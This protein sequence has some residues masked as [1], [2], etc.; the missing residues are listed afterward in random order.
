ME[1]LN[2]NS[3]NNNNLSIIDLGNCET[4]LKEKYNLNENDNLIILKKEKKTN[5][6]FEKEVQLEIYE[7]YNRT[8]LNISLCDETNINIYVKAKLSEEIKYSYEKLKSLGYDMFDINEPFYRDI[9]IDYTSYKDS[10]I[11]LSDRINYIYNNDDT[12]CQSNCK[13]YEYSEEYL[14][15]SSTIDEEINNMNEKF[16]STKKYESFSNDMK[17]SA[18]KVL[19]CYNLVFTKCLMA[20]NIGGILVFT[21]FLIYLGCFIIFIIK[22]INPLK[23]KFQLKVE[24]KYNNNI[25]NNINNND[26]ML[27]SKIDI[28]TNT[29]NKKSSNAVNPPRRKSTIQ[30]LNINNILDENDND[31][32]K[33]NANKND[34]KLADALKNNKLIIR[35][36]NKIQTAIN[37]TSKI[38]LEKMKQT[39]IKD[40]SNNK[41]DIFY[42]KI[43]NNSNQ[44]KNNE[45]KNEIEVKEEELD[46]LELNELDYKEAIKLDKRSFIQIYW[47][48]LKREQP[49]IFT[50]FIFDDYINLIYIK[51]VRFI[52]ILL[53]DMTMNVFSFLQMKQ[54]INYI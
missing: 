15:C 2:N 52:F 38:D 9:C 51:L 22:R 27:S 25:I 18:Y 8:K 7:P 43:S 40:I 48:I 30:L 33:T 5:K 26:I 23:N 46:N 20:K 29:K 41:F 53:T 36:N 45:N 17:Y 11:I 1:T 6:A 47:G 10:D 49:I 21:F 14:N 44:N 24:E 50:F 28:F 35:R 34:T 39:N 42:D 16:K 37:Q 31:N 3:L 13:L 32:V 19:K 54:F 12:K 4:I